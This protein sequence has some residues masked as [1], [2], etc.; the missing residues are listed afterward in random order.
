MSSYVFLFSV[1]YIS[2]FPLWVSIL[3]IDC[4][5]IFCSSD[6]NIITEIISIFAI[7]II[8]LLCLIVL[9]TRMKKQ[10]SGDNCETF[11]LC[12]VKLN[13][14]IIVEFIFTFVLPLAAFDFCSWQGV[15]LFVFF[16]LLLFHILVSLFN[17]PMLCSLVFFGYKIYDCKYLDIDN[18][19][20][21]AAFICNKTIKANKKIVADNISNDF[22]FIVK[23]AE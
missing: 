7:L 12:E 5:N 8:L 23:T 19:I 10:K 9:H 20:H 3:F 14:K 15:V 4:T 6:P 21:E 2:F 16:F 13:K 11:T 18:N 17:Y 1:Y 22:Y